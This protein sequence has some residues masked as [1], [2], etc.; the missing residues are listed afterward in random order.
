[1]TAPTVHPA[2][3]STADEVA[4]AYDAVRDAID[5]AVLPGSPLRAAVR[6]WLTDHSLPPSLLLPVAA[7][8]GVGGVSVAVSAAMAFLL[9]TMRWLDDL[10]DR[11]PPEHR[12]PPEHQRRV[13]VIPHRAAR[14]D[15]PVVLAR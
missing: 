8:G 14:L 10:V 5:N 15:R 2:P 3:S 4:Q 6:G 13:G 9:L 11:D 12:R 7:A 1:M